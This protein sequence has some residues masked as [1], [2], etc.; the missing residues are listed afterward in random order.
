[1]TARGNRRE[2]LLYDGQDRQGFLGMVAVL[3][4]RFGIEVHAFVLMDDYYHLLLRPP[5]PNLSQ[6][7][8][9]RGKESE[10]RAASVCRLAE[11]VRWMEEL[12]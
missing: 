6:A 12:K 7:I 4:E 10:G 11:V 2:S 5:E 1:M 9:W 3:P 8:Q